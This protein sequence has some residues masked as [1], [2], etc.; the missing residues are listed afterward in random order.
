MGRRCQKTSK[1]AY[2]DG[3]WRSSV[4]NGN[5]DAR[6]YDN[7][8]N[9]DTRKRIMSFSKGNKIPCEK[10]CD[11]FPFWLPWILFPLTLCLRLAYILEPTNWWILHPDEIFQTMEGTMF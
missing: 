1:H 8:K 2:I 9:G 7:L 5:T 6:P 3:T 4:S 11:I 10:S